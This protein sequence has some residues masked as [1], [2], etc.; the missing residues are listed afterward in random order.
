MTGMHRLGMDGTAES[1]GVQLGF[2]G[3]ISISTTPQ[4]GA[5]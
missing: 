5:T 3:K 4:Q 1:V 2:K